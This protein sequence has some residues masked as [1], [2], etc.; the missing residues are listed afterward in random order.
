M[1]PSL[2]LSHA[3]A[4]TVISSAYP[5]ISE[6]IIIGLGTGYNVCIVWRQMIDIYIL[7]IL[8]LVETIKNGKK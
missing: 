3:H 1:R 6:L 7:D 2:S 8:R 4:Q 5:K